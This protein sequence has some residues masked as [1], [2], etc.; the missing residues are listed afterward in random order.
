M[1][2]LP[3]GLDQSS[4]ELFGFFTYELCVGHSRVWS[5]AQGRFGRPVR[6]TG[7]QHPTPALTCTISR[8][9][10]SV[11]MS[12]PY[13]NPVYQGT[14]LLGN[15]PQTEIWGALYTQVMQADGVSWRNILLGQKRMY[16]G[17]Q[18][19]LAYKRTVTEDLYGICAWSN[20]EISAILEAMGLPDDSPLSVLA[21]ELFRNFVPVADPIGVC[22]G[23]ERIYRTSRLEPVP[24]IC[25]C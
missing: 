9:S 21:I 1:V 11:I 2:P 17:K 15:N 16:A 4:K 18:D 12:A 5:T 8:N 7:V 13:A 25:C 23:K 22:L 24:A 20:D 10:S 6:I 19:T 14:S 3:P